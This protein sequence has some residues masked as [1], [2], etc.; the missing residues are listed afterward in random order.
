MPRIDFEFQVGDRVRLAG[1]S[2]CPVTS[3]SFRRT[4]IITR[5]YERNGYMYCD[6]R[7]T[8]ENYQY[9]DHLWT[10]CR[11]DTFEL[12]LRT[13]VKPKKKARY[14]EREYCYA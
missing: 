2:T 10:N 9:Q 1:Y 8:T 12:E 13:G 14:Q 11:N 4:F 3:D 7:E 5:E 6:A